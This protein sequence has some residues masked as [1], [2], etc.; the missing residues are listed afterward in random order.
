MVLP[1]EKFCF[2]VPIVARRD[3]TV[4][5]VVVELVWQAYDSHTNV[6]AVI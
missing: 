1:T 2:L 6:G 3:F 4:F 5:W